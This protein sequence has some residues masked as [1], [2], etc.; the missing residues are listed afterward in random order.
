DGCH[1]HGSRSGDALGKPSQV[2]GR[3][4]CGIILFVYLTLTESIVTDGRYARLLEMV[5]HARKANG[6]RG[7]SFGHEPGGGGV[8]S[9]GIERHYLRAVF[10]AITSR[11]HCGKKTSGS[12]SVVMLTGSQEIL[13]AR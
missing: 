4:N 13:L 8:Q 12:M 7:T 10:Q 6:G 2:N 11:V 1:H 3:A 9:W 5:S